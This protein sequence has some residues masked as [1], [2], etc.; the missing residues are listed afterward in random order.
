MDTWIGKD[1]YIDP[2]DKDAYNRFIA[3]H[4][5]ATESPVVLAEMIQFE[6]R[7][8]EMAIKTIFLFPGQME[9]TRFMKSRYGLVQ[10]IPYKIS[11]SGKKYCYVGYCN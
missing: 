5:M 8:N 7:M 6:K 11:T 4:V 2:L 9:L 10:E 1:A 3:K